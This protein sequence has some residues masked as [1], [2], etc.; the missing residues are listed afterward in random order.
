MQQSF[1][2]VSSFEPLEAIASCWPPDY[3]RT[4]H[5]DLPLQ[6]PQVKTFPQNK[7]P[8]SPASEQ[9]S[10]APALG[11]MCAVWLL[12]GPQGLI[13]TVTPNELL[14]EDS[15]EAGASAAR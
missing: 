2:Y 14:W 3:Y 8:T 1:H 10:H 15:D 12:W 9:P 4:L 5:L 6:L 11:Q 7:E 13:L